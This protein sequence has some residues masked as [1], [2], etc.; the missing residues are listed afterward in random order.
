MFHQ[1]VVRDPTPIIIRVRFPTR[2]ALERGQI[3]IVDGLSD[4]A[5]LTASASA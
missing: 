5:W 4:S 2:V 1:Q 3:A